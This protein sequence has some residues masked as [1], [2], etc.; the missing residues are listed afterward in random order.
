MKTHFETLQVHAGQEIDPQTLGRGYSLHLTTA[1]QFRDAQHAANLFELKEFGN[2]YT[3]LQ[4]PTT[5]VFEK[6]CAALE[7]GVAALATSS[8]MAAQLTAITTIMSAGDNFVA[9]P[10]LYGGTFNQFTNTLPRFGIEC[11]MAASDSV[12]DIAAQI[13]EN[14]KAIFVESIA[15]PAYSIPE[16]DKLAELAHSNGIVLIVDNTFGCCGYMCRPIDWG[17]D[18]VVHSSS[19]WIGGHGEVMGGV[20]IDAGKFDWG[21]SV[22]YPIMTEPAPSYH[23][24]RYWE[25]FGEIAFIIKARVEGLRDLGACQSPFNAH[26]K[27]LGLETLSLRVERE[28]Q[29]AME[30]AKW[31]TSHPAVERVI[32]PGLPTDTQYEKAQKYLQNGF[33]CV[34]SVVLKGDVTQTAKAVESLKMVSHLTNVGDCKTLV[35]HPASTTHQQLS[36]ESQVSCGVYPTLLRISLG[37]EHID[38]IKADFEQAF[39][40]ISK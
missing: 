22:K 14:T 3:R 32:Y 38:D 36:P 13:N 31:F 34:L 18:I 10:F 27:L 39:S 16:L 4:N 33:G 26:Q 20:I 37:I 8:G 29:N 17:A 12:E 25:T 15:N 5:D 24:M 7:G 21:A 30:L 1:Y 40:V 6:R 11:R 9:P 23:G 2:I 19:K 35:T 28:A